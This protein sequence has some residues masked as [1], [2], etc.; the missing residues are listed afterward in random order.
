LTERV[1]STE[2]KVNSTANDV[3]KENANIFEGKE[4]ELKD[5]FNS[6][7]EQVDKNYLGGVKALEQMKGGKKIEDL[8]GFNDIIKK[9]E[10]IK[11]SATAKLTEE[12][13]K[14]K[15]ELEDLK[16][17]EVNKI[18]NNKPKLDYFEHLSEGVK[19][20]VYNDGVK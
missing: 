20:S 17:T 11:T 4:K 14:A 8:L 10:D 13:T 18:D 6:V 5:H 9:F 1:N 12:E 7:K 3:K 16:K 2:S 19:N 15:K